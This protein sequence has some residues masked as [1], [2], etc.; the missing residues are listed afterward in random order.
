MLREFHAVVF[1]PALIKAAVKR[2]DEFLDRDF[3]FLNIVAFKETHKDLRRQYSG[4]LWMRELF[5]FA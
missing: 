4:L 2:P 3:K 5:M 1:K